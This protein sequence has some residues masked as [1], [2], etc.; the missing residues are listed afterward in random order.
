M[1]I[2]TCPPGSASHSSESF[3]RASLDPSHLT[4]AYG[5]KAPPSSDSFYFYLPTPLGSW[6]SQVPVF[7]ILIFLLDS[8]LDFSFLTNLDSLGKS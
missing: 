5:P 8:G 4:L 1:P 3:T 7:E 6:K 2:A